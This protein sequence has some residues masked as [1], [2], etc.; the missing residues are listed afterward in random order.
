MTAIAAG[1]TAEIVETTEQTWK[2][3]AKKIEVV[4]Q[5]KPGEEPYYPEYSPYTT[6][7]APPEPAK[8]SIVINVE[9]TGSVPY[10]S[11]IMHIAAIDLANPEKVVE[12]FDEDEEQMVLKFISWFESQ[13]FSEIIGY[14]VGFDYRFIFTR[15]MRFRIQAPVF[16]DARLF[17]VMQTMKQVKAEY[18]FGFNKPGT[19]DAWADYVLGMTPPMSQKAVLL[20]WESKEYDKI[21]KYNEY[22]VTATILLYALTKF[23]EGEVSA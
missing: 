7:A 20:A 17:D 19:L 21:A 18:V 15:L 9:T 2:P 4:L 8:H 5:P 13:G 10:E 23:V 6:F 3:G 14:N 11:R 12:F 16:M 1:V 22:K